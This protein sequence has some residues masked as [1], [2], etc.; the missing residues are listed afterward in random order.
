[1]KASSIWLFLLFLAATL[2]C[3]GK[4]EDGI[5]SVCDG[6]CANLL[7]RESARGTEERLPSRLSRLGMTGNGMRR[8]G[9]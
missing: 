1:M 6:L 8:F 2:G 5:D 9:S 4:Q 7:S 3:R